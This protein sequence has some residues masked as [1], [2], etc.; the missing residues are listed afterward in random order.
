MIL[1]MPPP[2]RLLATL[3]LCLAVALALPATAQNKTLLWDEIAVTA[4]LDAAG[5]LHVR[6]RQTIVF[7]GDWNGGERVFQSR[8]NQD[9]DLT[10][11]ARID[12]DGREIPLVEG[13]T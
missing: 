3:L 2:N 10:R 13:D 7:N 9:I 11:I 12:S 8:L 6:E 1:T 4:R 5:K